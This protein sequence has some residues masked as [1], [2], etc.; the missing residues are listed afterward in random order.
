MGRAFVTQPTFPN[1][2]NIRKF[3]NEFLGRVALVA[4]RP[5]RQHSRERSVGLPVCLSV[6]CIV[7]NGESDPDAVWHRKSDGPG[8]RQV[9]GIG[10]RSMGRGSF[11]AN[12]GRAIV[13]K[14]L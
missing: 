1:F 5:S 3:T 12:F 9:G 14:G 7:E 10:D 6:Q 11:G 2:V 4:Q 8:M 13:Q